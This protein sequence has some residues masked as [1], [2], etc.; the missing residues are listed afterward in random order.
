MKTRVWREQIEAAFTSWYAE[1]Q[2]RTSSRAWGNAQELDY[3]D[4]DSAESAI[5]SLQHSSQVIRAFS[6]ERF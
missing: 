5:Q 6:A 1:R 4:R 2:G 3:S